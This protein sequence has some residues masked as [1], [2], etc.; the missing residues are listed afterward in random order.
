MSAKMQLRARSVED[1]PRFVVGMDAHAYKLAVSIWDWSDRFNACLHREIKCVDVDAMVKAS[2]VRHETPH[3]GERPHDADVN[4]DSR[5]RPQDT[6]QHPNAILGK[7]VW[8][9]FQ[10]RTT[11]S[12]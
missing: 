12:V 7:R 9:I 5:F 8:Q 4:V 3:G 2:M 11:L 6:A 1:E 10:M